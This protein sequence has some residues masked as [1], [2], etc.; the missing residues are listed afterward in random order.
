MK[1]LVTILSESFACQHLFAA[2]GQS[3]EVGCHSHPDHGAHDSVY[4]SPNASKPQFHLDPHIM[5]E[6]LFI[7]G[8]PS[9]PV[10]TA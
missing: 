7:V 1:K 3:Q 10:L 9:V 2:A 6:I 5:P 8:Y 4:E